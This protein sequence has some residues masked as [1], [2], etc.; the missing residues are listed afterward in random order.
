MEFINIKNASDLCEYLGISNKKLRFLCYSNKKYK[1]TTF[2][3]KKKNKNETRTINSPIRQLLLIQQKIK[4]E[5]EKFYRYPSEVNGFIKGKSIIDNAKQHINKK[6]VINLDIEDF[7][8][9]IHYGRIYGLFRSKLFNFNKEI[10]HL[11]TCLLTCDGALPQGSPTSPIISNLIFYSTDKQIIKYC[12]N[13]S[14]VYSRYADDITISFDKTEYISLFFQNSMLKILNSEFENIFLNS[15]FSINQD[16]TRIQRYFMHQ[17]VTGVKVNTKLNLNKSLKYQIRGTLHAIEKYGIENS[18]KEYCKKNNI[19]YN[20][21]HQIKL[22]NK[23]S[24]LISYWGM[25][26][27]KYS[28]EYTF[29]AEKFN[30][31]IGK[32]HFNLSSCDKSI[33]LDKCILLIDY[34]NMIS[35]TAFFYRNLIITCNHCIDELIP[36]NNIYLFKNINY[37]IS[38]KASLIFKDV[39]KDI[40]IFKPSNDDEI[41]NLININKQISVGDK[42]Y[43]YGYPDYNNSTDF[44][45]SQI[46][47][48]ITNIRNYMSTKLYVVDCPVQ[49]GLSGGPVLNNSFNVIGMIVYGNKD[50]ST[51]KKENG[52]IN[53]DIIDKCIDNLKD[54]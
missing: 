47:G 24:G 30:K 23:L 20:S 15:G 45:T 54:N 46:E 51:S 4:C 8:P 37:A 1:Y 25:V 35:G 9:S 13:K 18:T 28:R 22:I 49:P 12:R 31:I 14:I 16:K 48:N 36:I 53:I 41:I 38:I 50:L 21:R 7:F 42:V 43:I 26:K 17:E 3:L 29:F 33:I 19:D 32:R 10:S 5:L 6:Y 44:L 27:G 40:A 2:E 39:H 34:D 52:F 11:L